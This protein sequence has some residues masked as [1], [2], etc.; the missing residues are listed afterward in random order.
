MLTAELTARVQERQS[1]LIISESGFT[2]GMQPI[3]TVPFD[4]NQD[5][6]HNYKSRDESILYKNREESRD[7]FL[8]Q[9][10]YFQNVRGRVL[11]TSEL[12]SSLLRIRR[13]ATN[14]IQGV[15]VQICIA[16]AQ[17]FA[18]L[19]LQIGL[20]PM[21]ETDK[22][23]LRIT[24]KDK[25]QRLHKR[26]SSKVGPSKGRSVQVLSVVKDEQ[27]L[28]KEAHQFF[29]GHQEFFFIFLQAADSYNFGVHLKSRLVA[30][31][32]DLERQNELNGFQERLARQ[33]LLAKFL[34]VLLFSPNWHPSGVSDVLKSAST[35]DLEIWTSVTDIPL[36]LCDFIENARNEHRLFGTIPWILELLRMAKWDK[37]SIQSGPYSQ[38]LLS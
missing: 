11:D 25:L 34:G 2:G 12:E 23:L 33:Q 17:L 31:I 27:S 5:S 9:L 16:F 15:Q 35:E 1:N 30:G 26:F 32:K 36:P 6:C 19:L 7:A 8:Y 28:E 29:P 38:L 14:V 20:V 21:E 10:R 37:I 22:E 13:S 3:L 24:D 4:E 18:N